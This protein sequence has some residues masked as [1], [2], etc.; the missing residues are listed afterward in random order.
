MGT[1][2]LRKTIVGSI[3]VGYKDP[4]SIFVQEID[5]TTLMFAG[6]ILDEGSIAI[7]MSP[8]DGDLES[9]ITVLDGTILVIV[10]GLGTLNRTYE[11]VLSFTSTVLRPYVSYFRVCIKEVGSC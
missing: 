9:T 4:N 5:P 3:P 11:F 1:L 7:S 8:A 6:E 2:G 10:S